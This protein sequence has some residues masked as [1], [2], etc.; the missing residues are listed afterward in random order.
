MIYGADSTI[1]HRDMILY[2]QH[3]DI[4]FTEFESL[5]PEVINEIEIFNMQT[6]SVNIYSDDV[7]I[8]DGK[9]VEEREE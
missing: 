7:E 6:R 1:M 4:D 9:R 3:G 5:T 8:V 2:E